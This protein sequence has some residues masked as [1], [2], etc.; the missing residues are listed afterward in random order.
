MPDTADQSHGVF[1]KSE[2]RGSTL[3]RVAV[4]QIGSSQVLSQLMSLE[5]FNDIKSF[6][7]HYGPGVYSAS[8][9]NEYQ[10]HFVGE[11]PR[12]VR[13]TILPPS[14]AVV[15]KSGILNFLE[16]SGPLQAS[17]GTAALSLFRNAGTLFTGR[18]SAT[19]QCTRV[20]I[21]P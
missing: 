4:L 11:I 17:N 20:L 16:P 18:H 19:S 6:R 15:M 7:W 1:R 8:N 10:E 21:S 13:L 14:C 2:D 3:A 9:R 12:C 5:F